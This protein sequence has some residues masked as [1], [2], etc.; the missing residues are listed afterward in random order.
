MISPIDGAY[1]G[2]MRE[3]HCA[4]DRTRFFARLGDFRLCIYSI[5][6]SARSPLLWRLRP[7][8]K[9]GVEAH[10]G[11]GPSGLARSSAVCCWRNCCVPPTSAIW[12]I[13][14]VHRINREGNP[15]SRAADRD[16]LKWADSGP[17]RVASG[18]SGV[19][20]EAGVPIQ[21]RSALK[22]KGTR[23]CLA[24]ETPGRGSSPTAATPPACAAVSLEGRIQGTLSPFALTL[25]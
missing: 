17:A 11:L 8:S 2:P 4:P 25:G 13:P 1:D 3:D 19:P 18:K 7:A 14:P 12:C 10:D 6:E 21:R 20:P 23:P 24:K 15:G 9:P 5:R 22:A 16:R